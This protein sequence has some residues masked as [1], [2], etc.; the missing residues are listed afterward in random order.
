MLVE[1]LPLVCSL[2]VLPVGKCVV[3]VSLSVGVELLPVSV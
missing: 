1:D 2:I 3:I